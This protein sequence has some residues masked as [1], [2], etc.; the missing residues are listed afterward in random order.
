MRL[1]LIVALCCCV[2]PPNILQARATIA[3]LKSASA[4]AAANVTA[5][6]T[7]ASISASTVNSSPSVLR[8]DWAAAERRLLSQLA[9][10]RRECMQTETKIE[11]SIFALFVARIVHYADV[12]SSNIFEF[13]LYICMSLYKPS[14]VLLTN[15]ETRMHIPTFPHRQDLTIELADAAAATA[16]LRTEHSALTAQI[17]T[18]SHSLAAATATIA[19]LQSDLA[20]S[21]HAQKQAVTALA[22]AETRLQSAQTQAEIV[23][24]ETEARLAAKE[25]ERETALRQWADTSA[26][27]TNVQRALTDANAQVYRNMCYVYVCVFLARCCSMLPIFA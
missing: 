23:R 24:A 5:P 13:E 15:V 1:K 17:A 6:A 12:W 16:A 4:S 14:L 20:S 7:P 22:E 21:Q 11:V 25:A 2:F 10:A 3:S 9:A 18:H 8:S 26:A 19:A 27:L